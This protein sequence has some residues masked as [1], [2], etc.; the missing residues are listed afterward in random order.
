MERL[1]VT[2]PKEVKERIR[3]KQT[4]ISSFVRSAIKH[5]LQQQEGCKRYLKT[6]KGKERHRKANDKWRKS[7]LVEM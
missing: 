4:T 7:K 3:Q 1:Y 6:T 2:I 5:Y